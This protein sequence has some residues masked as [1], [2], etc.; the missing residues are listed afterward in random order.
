MPIAD[1]NPCNPLRNCL[2][3]SAGPGHSIRP[4]WCALTV[5]ERKSLSCRDPCPLRR[6]Q[7][8]VIRLRPELGRE[9][10]LR[11]L[12]TPSMMLASHRHCDHPRVVTRLFRGGL[13]SRPRWLWLFEREAGCLSEFAGLT[14]GGN[15]IRTVRPS[16]ELV[17]PARSTVSRGPWAHVRNGRI[18]SAV[19]QAR[20]GF[21]PAVSCANQWFLSSAEQ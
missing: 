20:I 8:E 17:L 9:G 14:A 5:S 10:V 7:S 6:S 11:Y 3:R 12:S 16:P 2:P 18:P 19:R 1:C 4:W 15:G 21:A 13:R